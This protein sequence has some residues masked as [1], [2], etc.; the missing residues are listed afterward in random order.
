MT[1]KTIIRVS[2][3]MLTK[4]DLTDGTA[5][6]AEALRSAEH[7]ETGCILVDRRDENDEYGI[8][9]LSD[10]AKQVLAVDKAPDRVNVY[11]I[12]SK[13]VIYIHPKMDIRYCARL[14]EKFGITR[15]PVIKDQVILG[16]VSYRDIVLLG[17]RPH[18]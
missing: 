13:P 4:F 8:L 1:D 18:L 14:F 12:M 10:I 17:I 9:L 5:T 11:E 16:V 6:I 2:D 3:V 15:T 7:L